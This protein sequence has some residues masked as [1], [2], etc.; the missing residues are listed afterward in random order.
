M[1]Q[2]EKLT[3]EYLY[4]QIYRMLSV[5]SEDRLK[6]LD[7]LDDHQVQL[8]INRL[9]MVLVARRGGKFKAENGQKRDRR[10]Y[11]ACGIILEGR[12]RGSKS[13]KKTRRPC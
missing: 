9:K 11:R 6:D 8:L 4:E 12:A 3:L 7:E 13:A 2:S 5:E 1:T 10:S